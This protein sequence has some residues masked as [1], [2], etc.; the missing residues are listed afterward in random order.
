MK[1]QQMKL[2]GL[3]RGNHEPFWYMRSLQ[4]VMKK[5]DITSVWM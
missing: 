5:Q 1:K 2:K 4:E 3:H